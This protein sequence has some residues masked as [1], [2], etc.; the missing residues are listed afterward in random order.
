MLA[1]TEAPSP[2]VPQEGI[3]RANQAAGAETAA[4][5]WHENCFISST[6]SFCGTGSAAP[7]RGGRR[8]FPLLE[9][10]NK[11]RNM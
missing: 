6:A 5:I 8:V 7:R 4:Y 9:A 1:P 3:R 10:A 2:S 11:N